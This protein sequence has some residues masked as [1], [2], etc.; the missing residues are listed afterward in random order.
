MS[1][2]CLHMLHR[3]SSN[4]VL[5]FR[6]SIST[7]EKTTRQMNVSI[8]SLR[9]IVSRPSSNI[10]LCSTRRIFDFRPQSNRSCSRLDARN[11]SFKHTLHC[12]TLFDMF[13]QDTLVLF[14]LLLREFATK[15]FSVARGQG[16]KTMSVTTIH[17]PNIQKW[18]L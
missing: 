6:S 4:I 10:V 9:V 17:Q 7:V 11:T 3:P 14:N 5:G 13:M 12:T 15:I 18:L 8:T 1:S 16:R 2:A